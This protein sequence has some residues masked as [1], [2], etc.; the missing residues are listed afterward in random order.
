MDL[1]REREVTERLCRDAAAIV[2]GYFGS[3]IAVEQKPGEGPVT[4]ADRE[5]S[6]LIVRGLRAA[7]PNDGI[8]S[9]EASDDGSRVGAE[10]V[11]MIDPL[12]G[13]SDFVRG[14]DGFAVMVGLL[15]GDRPALGMVLQ[16]T[17]GVLYRASLGAGAERVGPDGQVSYLRVS[18]VDDFAAVR[19]VA[20]KSH[21]GESIDRVRAALGITDEFNIGSVGLK[22]GLIA[23]GER[24]L[25]V[26]PESHSSLWDTLAPEAI[27]VEAGGRLSD[28]GGA[29]LDYR[30]TN[31]KNRRGLVASNGLL[32]DAVTEK[33]RPLFLAQSAARK[34]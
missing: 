27:L 14:R 4:Q 22:L 5:A 20:S 33:M 3:G 32:H 29:P 25:Y 24:D 31:V 23:R 7:F 2:K 34:N 15:V 12:D 17:S 18:A 1:G 9:E 26:N 11:W 6:E 16:P 30:A 13:T 19:L 8:L 28:L 21:R 10:R